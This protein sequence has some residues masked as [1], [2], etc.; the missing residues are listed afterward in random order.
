MRDGLDPIFDEENYDS[1]AA[2]RDGFNEGYKV[3]QAAAHK[4]LAARVLVESQSYEHRNGE[5]TPP[6]V[7]GWY[8]VEMQPDLMMPVTFWYMI[9]WH[10]NGWA[11]P[12]VYPLAIFGP[13]QPPPQKVSEL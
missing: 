13:I 2:Y 9:E 6:E 4:L 11:Y 1:E 12:S 7:E 3:G 8:W 10:D 5:T